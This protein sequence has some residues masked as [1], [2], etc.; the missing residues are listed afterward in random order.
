M[1]PAGGVGG[2]GGDVFTAESEVSE[3]G[4][5]CSAAS[6]WHSDKSSWMAVIAGSLA[7]S[8]HGGAGAPG[9]SVSL[10]GFSNVLKLETEESVD[11]V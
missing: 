2:G 7:Q 3:V 8:T 1:D 9:E 5:G 4:A 11:R 6:T 10:V